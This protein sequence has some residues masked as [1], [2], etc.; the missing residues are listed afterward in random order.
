M[1]S[2][3]VY[4]ACSCDSIIRADD[5]G[6]CFLLYPLSR[7]VDALEAVVCCELVYIIKVV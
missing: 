6:C 5:I 1:Y 3:A 4:K 7:L 2:I